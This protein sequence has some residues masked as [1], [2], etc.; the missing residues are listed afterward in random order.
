MTKNKRIQVGPVAKKILLLLKTGT[1][2]SLTR[3]PD[4]YFRILRQTGREWKKINEESL[5][6]AIKRLYQ[7]KLVGCREHSDGT[8]ELVLADEGKQR[9]LRY[10]LDTMEINKPT[11][12]D[13]LWR[14]VM[15]DI[16]ERHKKGR[17][18]L[19]WK[20]KELGFYPLQ[21]KRI[22]LSL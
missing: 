4:A 22:C 1:A 3:R 7:S 11:T 18:A 21:K 6:R 17:D 13:T 14:I 9:S 5:H 19:A 10:Q 2:L 8:V 15:F 16:P 20:L 12:W